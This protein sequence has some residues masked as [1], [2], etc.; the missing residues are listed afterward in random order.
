MLFLTS[1]GQNMNLSEVDIHAKGEVDTVRKIQE[2]HRKRTI[3][4]VEKNDMSASGVLLRMINVIVAK[5]WGFGG[6]YVDIN[7]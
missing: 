2:N 5:R 6:R 7:L 4:I 3:P 1:V